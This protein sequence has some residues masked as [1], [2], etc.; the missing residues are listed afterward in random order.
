MDSFSSFPLCHYYFIH[1]LRKYRLSLLRRFLGQYSNN[2][3][4][5]A[6][7]PAGEV[8]YNTPHISVYQHSP[9]ISNNFHN[10]LSPKGYFYANWL[11][12]LIIFMVFYDV[13]L[14]FDISSDLWKIY[15]MIFFLCAGIYMVAEKLKA[16]NN[17]SI[18]KRVSFQMLL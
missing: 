15:L 11:D 8:N 14:I 12:V 9:T 10:F 5:K 3:A 18:M 4:L 16:R 7:L 2:K 1:L 6:N 17:K 13:S